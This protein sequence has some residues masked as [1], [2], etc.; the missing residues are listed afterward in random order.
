MK[1][2]FPLTSLVIVV[3]LMVTCSAS[4]NNGI[5]NNKVT[6]WDSII[7]GQAIQ[8]KLGDSVT[9]IISK[10]DAAIINKV[11]TVE[12]TDTISNEKY[13]VNK[14]TELGALN[15]EQK[16][17][18][19]FILLSDSTYVWKKIN[20]KH[21]FEPELLFSLYS[22]SEKVNV[23]YS[24]NSYQ[25]AFAYKDYMEYIMIKKNILTEDYFKKL[26]M[27]FAKNDTIKKK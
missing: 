8:L 21:S 22:E 11:D 27:V 18:L 25:I 20:I 15:P 7:V 24:P 12:K 6:K 17:I 9:D 10:S 23:I 14:Y 16:A 5:N 1:K 26:K 4:L 2:I 3:M 19:K 13:T